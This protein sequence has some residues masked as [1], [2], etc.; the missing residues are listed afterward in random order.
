MYIGF[1]WWDLRERDHLEDLDIW[2]VSFKMDLQE[3]VWVGTDWID[4]AYGRDSWLAVVIAVMN[5]RV[6]QN[7]GNFWTSCGTVSF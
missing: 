5:L 2:E 3:V 6:P 4:L 7:E 1:W